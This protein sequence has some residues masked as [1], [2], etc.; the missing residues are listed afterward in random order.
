[1]HH[2]QVSIFLAAIVGPGRRSLD[3]NKVTWKVDANCKSRCAADNA[4][5]VG[6][7]GLLNSTAIEYIETCVME[8]NT[9]RD[10]F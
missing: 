7:K 5:I 1:L 9:S 8:C 3:N 2:L 4:D 6:Q 10:E